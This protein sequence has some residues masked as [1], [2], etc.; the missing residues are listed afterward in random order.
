MALLDVQ[1]KVFNDLIESLRQEIKINRDESSEKI[2]ELVKS[3][4]FSQ[5][6]I[7]DLKKKMEATCKEKLKYERQVPALTGENEAIKKKL[8]ESED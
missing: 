8:E 5:A 6:E 2:G 3:L 7:E 4:E 1:R